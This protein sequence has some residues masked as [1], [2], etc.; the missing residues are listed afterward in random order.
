MMVLYNITP[1]I[2]LVSNCIAMMVF[3]EQSN[4]NITKT[5]KLSTSQHGSVQSMSSFDVHLLYSLLGL[6]ALA[7]LSVSHTWESTN[8]LALIESCNF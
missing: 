3:G 6:E 8:I 1:K 2:H 7:S 4:P 5:A